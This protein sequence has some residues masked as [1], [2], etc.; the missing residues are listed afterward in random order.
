MV[1]NGAICA[2]RVG[3]WD[4][5]AALLEEW[6]ERETDD[7]LRVEFRIDRAI[8]HAHRGPGSV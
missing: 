4:W 7:K 5:A 1:G 6:L 3:E 2:I 8:L